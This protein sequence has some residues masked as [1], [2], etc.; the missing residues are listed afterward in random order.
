MKEGAKAAVEGTSIKI[1]MILWLHYYFLWRTGCF[2]LPLFGCARKN[3]KAHGTMNACGIFWF[4][5]GCIFD[6]SLRFVICGR[7]H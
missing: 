7:W 1:S 5:V 3:K 2:H 4:R 6:A